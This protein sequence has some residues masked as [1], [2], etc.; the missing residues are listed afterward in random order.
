MSAELIERLKRL[1]SEE[2]DMGR[3]HMADLLDE[4]RGALVKQ[5]PLTDEQIEEMPVWRHFVGLLP[6]TRREITQAIEQAHGIGEQ[7]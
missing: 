3:R 7:A 4:C 2:R 5:Q 6:E 1:E